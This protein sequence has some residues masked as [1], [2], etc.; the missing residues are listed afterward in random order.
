M[1]L[2]LC[3]GRSLPPGRFLVHDALSNSLT[4]PSPSWDAAKC[5]VTQELPSILW[6]S[7]T[8][9]LNSCFLFWRSSFY[10]P[11]R[12]GVTILEFFRSFPQDFKANAAIIQ[13]TKTCYCIIISSSLFMYHC[14]MWRLTVII[15][16][17]YLSIYSSFLN[18]GRFLSFLIP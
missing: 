7:Q 10:D 5:A 14:I 8:N 12:L 13:I 2:D 11:T 18:F 4:E 15:Y 17:I 1:L 9:G 3:A 16:L 6:K